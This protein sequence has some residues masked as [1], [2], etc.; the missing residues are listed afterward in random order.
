MLKIRQEMLVKK[1]DGRTLSFDRE[2]IARAIRKAF[3]A[4]LGLDQLDQIDPDK[5]ADIERMTESVV[6]RV[7][8]QAD[9]DEGVDVESIQDKVEQELMRAEYFSVA[10]RYIIYRAE[11]KRVRRL[12]AEENLETSGTDAFPE[13]MVNRDGRLEN[14]DFSRLRRQVTDACV[15][16]KESCSSTEL[17]EEIEKQFYNGITPKEIGR[18]MVLAARSRIENDPSYDAVASRLMLNIIYRE[19][20]DKQSGSDDLATLYEKQFSRYIGIGVEAG[21]ISSELKSF[22]LEKLAQAIDCE[23]DSLFPYLGLQTIYDRYLLHIEGRR[24][25]AP[26]Y[27]WMRVAMG[28]SINEGENKNDRAIEFYNILS[29][30]RFTSATPTLFNAGTCHP[31][32]SSCYLSTVDDDLDHI[33]KVISDNAK[34]SKWAGG[35][36]NDWTNIRATNSHISGTN[37]QSQGVIPFLKVVSDTAVAVNQGGKRKGAVCS[38]LETWHMDIEEFLDLRKNTGDDRR[39]THDMHTANWIPDLFMKRLFADQEWTLFSPDETPDLHDLVGSKFEE[40][41]EHYEQLAEQGKIK[42]SKKIPAKE[43]WRKMLT[44]LFETGHPWITFK[45]PSNVRSPQDHVG[46]V[47]SSNLCTEILLNTSKDETA[48]CNLGSINLRNHITDGQLDL[49]KLKVTVDTAVRM[50]DNVID[51][52]FYPTDEAKNANKRHRPVG[53]GLMGFQDAIAACGYSYASDDAVEFADR[54]MEAISYYAILASSKLADERGTYG[55][56]EGSKW[57]RGL[58]PI[59]TIDLLEQ[60]RGVP[61]EMDRSSTMD[62]DTVRAQVAKHGMRNSNVMA[63]APTATISTIIGVTQSIE[64]TYK[65]LFVKSNLSGEFVQVNI[66]LINE[67]KKRDLWN[68]DLLE[69]IKYYDG[70]LGDIEGLPDDIKDRYATAFEIEPKWIIECAS[71]RQKWLDMGQSLNLYIEQASGKQLD[72]MYRMAWT[73]GLKTTYYLRSLGA[74]QVEKSTVDINKFSVQPRWMKNQSASAEVVVSRQPEVQQCRIDDP[75]CEACQ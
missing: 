63:I 16:L 20:L 35:L 60:E 74:T 42:L 9:T 68:D 7:K 71:R 70:S 33:F 62:W 57:D 26:Q 12:R 51:I 67:L 66:S 69:A 17:F 48:V 15:G 11:R 41:Y 28:L 72:E 36:G 30:F 59:D 65:H 32:L 43:L 55:S 21:R 50:L 6:K 39:R 47:H 22:D 46:V 38:Y 14:I 3:R 34:L 31:Q 27:F 54:S 4:D 64:P 19:S 1:R 44:R 45:D 10:R 18:A 49:E 25:E 61:V 53:L 24:I 13:I 8:D 40:R 23:R 75:D 56:Y 5:L 2:L 29:T 52:N 58:L 73:R 37:G